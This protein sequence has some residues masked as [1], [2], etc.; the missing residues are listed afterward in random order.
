MWNKLFCFKSVL[1]D[2]PDCQ[3]SQKI[4]AK[5][6][7]VRT[8]ARIKIKRMRT[9]FSHRL[10]CAAISSCSV[11]VNDFQIIHNTFPKD[12]YLFQ[13]PNTH[14][15][16]RPSQDD[17]PKIA[18]SMDNDDGFYDDDDD[19]GERV[20]VKMQ[21]SQGQEQQQECPK[22]HSLGMLSRDKRNRMRK[23]GMKVVVKKD[24]IL[25][26]CR[27]WRR[28]LRKPV[29]RRK[30]R[31]SKFPWG[32]GEWSNFLVEPI[33]TAFEAWLNEGISIFLFECITELLPLIVNAAVA[34]PV[35]APTI[36]A[37]APPDDS[38]AETCAFKTLYRAENSLNDLKMLCR[39]NGRRE[40]EELRSA[41]QTWYLE[42]FRLRA[43]LGVPLAGIF[44]SGRPSLR[45]SE[46]GSS[47]TKS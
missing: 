45:D 47:P 44:A 19:K 30:M 15:P 11:R 40:I 39:K 34:K 37:P 33:E 13:V 29:V 6:S 12:P 3:K 18:I 38:E 41:L 22:R 25:Q 23:L 27:R 4:C 42:N 17:R 9:S 2:A 43:P 21:L 26:V 46:S 10:Y 5:F 36:L 28:W 1:C 20:I 32:G 35:A 16:E 14:L 7:T 24:I 8:Y 31:F